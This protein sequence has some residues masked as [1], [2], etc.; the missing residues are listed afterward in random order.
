MSETVLHLDS[1]FLIFLLEGGQ[2]FT[3]PPELLGDLNSEDA[4]KHIDG[5]SHSIASIV[6]HLDYWQTWFL[7]GVE[8][9]LEPYPD[10]FGSTFFPIES[11]QWQ[12]LRSNLLNN[13]NKIKE[14]CKDAD[15]LKRPFSMGES[16]GGGHDDR[17]VGM[18]LLYTVVVHNAHHY[19]QIVTM[20]QIM[21]LWPPVG[22][23]IS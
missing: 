18:T 2:A 8:G 19:G 9:K 14:I 5:A 21:S 11:D 15:L 20:R 13:K 12:D 6:S 22:G 17:S 3:N 7:Q 16:L 1:E 10:S 23:G 4:V